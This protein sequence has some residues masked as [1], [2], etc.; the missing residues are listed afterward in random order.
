M[1]PDKRD[2]FR[3]ILCLILKKIA[4]DEN[5]KNHLDFCKELGGIPVYKKPEEKLSSKLSTSSKENLNEVLMKEAA[6]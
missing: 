6:K 4:D 3:D 5:I 1:N 2:T